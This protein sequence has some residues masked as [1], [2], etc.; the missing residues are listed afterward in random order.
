MEHNEK[1]L[2]DDLSKTLNQHSFAMQDLSERSVELSNALN[3]RHPIPPE[4]KV[5]ESRD[6]VKLKEIKEWARE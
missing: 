2:L 5:F 3:P 4:R 6:K 1:N